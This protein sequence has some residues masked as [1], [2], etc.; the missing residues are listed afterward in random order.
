MMIRRY[1]E[2]FECDLFC[3]DFDTFTGPYR[4]VVVR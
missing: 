2:T 3:A 1:I 4:V